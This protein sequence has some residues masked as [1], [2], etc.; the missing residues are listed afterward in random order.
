MLR[1]VGNMKARSIGIF[2]QYLNTAL[3]MA[4]GLFLS[5]FLVRVLGDTE[6]GLYQTICSFVNYLVLLEFGTGT[7][8]ARNIAASRAENDKEKIQKNVSTIWAITCILVVVI[9]IVSMIFYRFL[10]TIYSKTLTVEQIQYGRKIFL[11]VL[12]FLIA[13][14][15]TNTLNGVLLGFER[16][17]LQPIVTTI[18]LITR[19]VFLV[20][21]V[22]VFRKSI[23]IACVDLIIATAVDVFLI[24]YCHRNFEIK[25]H[26]K[27]FDW[28]VFKN[29]L[30]L[31][32]AIFI[33]VLINQAN[34]SVDKFVIGVKLG[35]EEV[36]VYSV[37]LFVYGVFSSMT[38]I[39]ISMYAPQVVKT[40]TCGHSP[41]EVSRQ[42]V[43]PS[44]LIV[45][46]GGTVLFGFF[47]VGRQFVTIVY[48]VSYV[49]AWEVALI[50]MT[51]MLINMSNGIL[52]NILNA[53]NKRLARSGILLITTIANIVLTVLWIDKYG[54]LGACVATAVCTILG[55]ILLMD[56]YYNKALHINIILFK[57]NTFRGIALY[58]II[59]GGIAFFIGRYITNVIVSFFVGG[60]AYVSLFSGLFWLFGA[61]S[62][63]KGIVIRLFHRVRHRKQ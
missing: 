53:T 43:Q 12:G 35:P 9:L 36:T 54:V 15:Y 62:D 57:L 7:V 2:L 30:P 10:G 14:F 52:V 37:G 28:C 27:E 48:G 5:A 17:E 56:L 25:F 63:E 58:Q 32:T 4:C 49:L 18:R 24:V 42:L 23:V 21:A 13:S 3:S 29:S 20:I 47:A 8:I 60:F 22:L 61:S 16:Y 33:Q 38:T 31:A 44:R 46:I 26:F 40:I 6:Y 19:T 11:T 51:P 50:I 1:Q 45:L 55:Q 41:D 34:N 39:P 59:A